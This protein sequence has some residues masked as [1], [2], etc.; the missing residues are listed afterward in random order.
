MIPRDYITE[1]RRQAPWIQDFQVKQDL[2]VSKALV[3]IFS[4][5]VLSKA[6]AFR[7]GAESSRSMARRA[8]VEADRRPSHVR[9][10][11]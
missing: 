1:W 6:V 9:L 8:A 10:S 3:N 4:D 7:G 11:L 5:P 2:I